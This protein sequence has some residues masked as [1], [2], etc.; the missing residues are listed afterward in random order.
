M[1]DTTPDL[2]ERISD[3]GEDTLAANEGLHLTF[4]QGSRN[5]LQ[6]RLIGQAGR[7]GHAYRWRSG[8]TFAQRS[9]GH[10]GKGLIGDM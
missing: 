8:V 6:T 1:L 2:F 7:W 9:N 5:M 10:L 3:F 4:Y